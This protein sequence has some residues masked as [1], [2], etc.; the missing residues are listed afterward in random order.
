[1]VIRGTPKD[2]DS[3]ILTNDII[4]DK[5]QINGFSPKYIDSNGLYFKKSKELLNFMERSIH[6]ER[7]D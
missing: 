2:L 3:Y 7:K 1:M 6:F 4:G 5:L